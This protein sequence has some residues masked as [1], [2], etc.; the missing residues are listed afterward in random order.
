MRRTLLLLGAGLAASLLFGWVA[1]PH[2]LYRR[3]DQ[4]VQFSHAT[5]TREALG[6]AC[7]DCHALSPDGRFTGIPPLATCARCHDGMAGS[8]PAE[9]AMIER[10]VSRG[11][12]IP[13]LVYA[14][15]PGNVFFPHAAHVSL[16]GL[17]CERCHGDHARTASLRPLERNRVSGYSR[18]IW[19]RSLSRLRRAPGEGMKMSDCESCHRER[20]V[21]TGCLACH[22]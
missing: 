12:E 20:R 6:L 11:V 9:K 15:Q 13:W 22:K 18:D 19:G 3:I 4:P 2:V 17:P 16:A 10:Y 1:L 8:S 21:H 7:D 5:H 14:R